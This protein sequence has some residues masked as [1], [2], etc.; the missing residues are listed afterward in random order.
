[1]ILAG[2]AV[3]IVGWLILFLQVVQVCSNSLYLSILAHALSFIG[4]IV[5]LIGLFYWRGERWR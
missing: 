3:M 5:G 1:M 4:L 2:L